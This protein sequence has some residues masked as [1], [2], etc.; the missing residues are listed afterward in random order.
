M[1]KSLAT[2]GEELTMTTLQRFV[3][4]QV[5]INQ[6]Q[7]HEL[8]LVNSEENKE[9]VV[10]ELTLRALKDDPTVSEPGWSFLKGARNTA[11]HGLDQWLLNW[12]VST[13]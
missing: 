5:E 3:S 7:L 10:L 6:S 11:L 4:E 9:D 13:N 2:N 8:L 12:V 1:E